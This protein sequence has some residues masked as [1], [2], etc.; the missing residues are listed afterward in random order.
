[1]RH[2]TDDE[3]RS[4]RYVAVVGPSVCTRVQQ[5]VAERLGRALAERGDVVLCGGGDGVMAAVARGATESGGVVVGIL[6]GDDRHA[7]NPWVT[8]ALAT[9]L[10]ELRNGLIV[11]AADAVVAV[12]GSW[13]T[14]SEV[15]MATRT[16][17]P[18]VSLDG[19]TPAVAGTSAAQDG[20][21]GPVEAGTVDEAL[22]TLD[23]LLR[24]RR[25]GVQLHG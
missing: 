20:V 7:A 3:S 15:A 16:G 21:P 22:A 9:G 5:D 6:P 2:A 17:V 1:M 13:G 8:I 14:L 11:R 23:R 25:D 24:V 10:G 18:V 12:G 19:W 4:G